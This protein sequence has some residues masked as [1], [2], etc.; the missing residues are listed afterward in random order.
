MKEKNIRMHVQLLT[1]DNGT[2]LQLGFA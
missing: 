2:I 1:T